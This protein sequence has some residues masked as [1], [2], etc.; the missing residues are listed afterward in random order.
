MTLFPAAT[1]AA[2][3]VT[4]SDVPV[5]VLPVFP[6]FFTN[7]T[8]APALIGQRAA[9]RI[10]TSARCRQRRVVVFGDRGA[11]LVGIVDLFSWRRS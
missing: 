3:T 2:G 7:V 11:A 4:E 10:R 6:M 8:A 9:R 1:S 5:V